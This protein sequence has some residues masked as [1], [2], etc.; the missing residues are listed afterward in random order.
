MSDGHGHGHGH[1]AA[2]G[3]TGRISKV[4][5]WFLVLSIIVACIQGTFVV[6]SSGSGKI[7]PSS[8]A[9]KLPLDGSKP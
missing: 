2:D 7:W 5:W 3:G 8:N 4:V 9:V 1:S 6:M